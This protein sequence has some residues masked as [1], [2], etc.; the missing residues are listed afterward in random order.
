MPRD[1]HD[2]D[3]RCALWLRVSGS[4][5]D[6]ANQLRPLEA[7]AG[8]RGLEVARVFDVTASGYAGQQE[9]QLTELVNGIRRREYGTVISWAIDRLTRRGVSETLQAV[10][11]ITKAGGTLVSIQ[12]PGSKRPMNYVSCS[13]PWWAGWRTSIPS[14]AA[15]ASRRA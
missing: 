15:S 2:P 8:R 3:D 9:R 13:S 6:T 12:E 7:E 5:Q 4:S 11:S 14:A 1:P 10:N